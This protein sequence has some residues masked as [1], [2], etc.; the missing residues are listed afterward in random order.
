MP[1]PFLHEIGCEEIPDWMIVPAL[2]S[3][4]ELIEKVIAENHLG[5]EVSWTD[6]TPRRLV[7]YVEGLKER[8]DDS[9][10]VVMGPPKAANPN[11]VA[12]FA[13]K[14]GVETADLKTFK[15]NK[16]EYYG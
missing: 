7:I 1:V 5:G 13:K 2:K 6:A 12:G 15:S 4:Q 3:L 11:A 16:G 10:E 9:E 14:Q 8:Q